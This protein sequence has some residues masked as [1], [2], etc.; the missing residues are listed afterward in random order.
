M[1]VAPGSDQRRN[2]KKAGIEYHFGR[3]LSREGMY[4]SEHMFQLSHDMEFFPTRQ[5]IC[6]EKSDNGLVGH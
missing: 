1:T 5:Q 3:C 2:M 4:E 6:D